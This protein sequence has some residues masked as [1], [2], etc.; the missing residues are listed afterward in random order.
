MWSNL[1]TGA[2]CYY[3]NN[4]N[5]G[6]LY[7]WYAVNDSRGLAPE[8]WHIPST[9]EWT[10]LIN[11][12]GGAQTA[13]NK[14][15]SENGWNDN[16]NGN[17]KSGFTALPCGYRNNSGAYFDFGNKALWWTKTSVNSVILGVVFDAYCVGLDKNEDI[18]TSNYG[19][20]YYGLS[21]RCIKD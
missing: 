11:N 4:P 20:V 6:K 9:D 12:L 21:V 3:E 13:G 19:P 14:L 17:N 7:N 5:N 1:T 16:G 10:D 2:W 15:K 18:V 8:G